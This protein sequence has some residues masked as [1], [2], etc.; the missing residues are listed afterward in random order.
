MTIIKG[1]HDPQHLNNQ[2]LF[3]FL[4]PLKRE[5]DIEVNDANFDMSLCCGWFWCCLYGNS[6]LLGGVVD[7]E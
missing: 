5:I 1:H 4:V 6:G 2:A 3:Y 7:K